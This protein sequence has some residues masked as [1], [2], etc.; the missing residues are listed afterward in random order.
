MPCGRPVVG[1]PPDAFGARK[2]RKA[3]GERSA[4]RSSGRAAQSRTAERRITPSQ[5]VDQI[6]FLKIVCTW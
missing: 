6:Q 1:H 4:V 3:K 2:S 5:D